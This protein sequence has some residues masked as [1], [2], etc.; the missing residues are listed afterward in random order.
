MSEKLKKKPECG[1]ITTA[2]TIHR[3]WE[4]VERFDEYGKESYAM[5]TRSQPN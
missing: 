4:L 5:V 1:R 2:D 3:A